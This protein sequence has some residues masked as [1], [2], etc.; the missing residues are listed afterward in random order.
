QATTASNTVHDEVVRNAINMAKAA[1]QNANI[2]SLRTKADAFIYGLALS[3]RDDSLSTRYS[4]Q[5]FSWGSADNHGLFRAATESVKQFKDAAK[6]VGYIALEAPL[7]KIVTDES[8]NNIKLGFWSDIFAR[9]LNSSNVVDP[10]TG[11]PTSGLD[12]NSRLRTQFVANGLSL[13]GSQVRLF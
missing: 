11:G 2:G 13:N 6:D 3:K 10:I 1:A 7:A 4:N 12:T 9:E 8:D 5:G